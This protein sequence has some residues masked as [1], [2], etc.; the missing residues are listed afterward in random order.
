[1]P[2]IATTTTGERS[3]RTTNSAGR[4][5]SEEY[6]PADVVKLPPRYAFAFLLLKYFGF[7]VLVAMAFG[8]WIFH[9]DAQ[10]RID[11]ESDRAAF[12]GAIDRN[13]DRLTELVQE[14]R[15]LE[16]SHR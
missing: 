11:R 13:T 9:Q 4:F 10:A 7:P 3:E 2:E 8:Y 12:V 14:I 1:M 5:S 16:D 6:D 15:R